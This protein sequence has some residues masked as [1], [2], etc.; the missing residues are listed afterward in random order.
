MRKRW[1]I[2]IAILVILIFFIFTKT[3]FG[4]KRLFKGATADEYYAGI[5]FAYYEDGYLISYG[6]MIRL[7][8]RIPG[9]DAQS[10]QVISGHYVKDKNYVYNRGKR[11]QNIDGKTFTHF[12]E[13]LRFGKD[14]Y[15]VF[16]MPDFLIDQRVVPIEGVDVPSFQMLCRIYGKDKNSVFA[17][18]FASH[19]ESEYGVTL[20]WT[21]RRM[22]DADTNTFECVDRYPL[23]DIGRDK[24]RVYRS[25]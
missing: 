17:R 18:Q 21:L 9:S 25:E 5:F 20:T 4:K 14:Q 16:D 6:S 23:P 7:V 22:P 24:N 3:T 15:S 10:M 12:G 11:V 13:F 1:L 19:I 2:L 8:K